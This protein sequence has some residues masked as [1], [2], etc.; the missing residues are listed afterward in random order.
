[1]DP[2]NYEA[3]CNRA[4]VKIKMKNFEK[5]LFDIETAI[6]VNEMYVD[7]WCLSLLAYVSLGNEKR[8]EQ[9]IGYITHLDMQRKAFDI[10]KEYVNKFEHFNVEWFKVLV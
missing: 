6:E 4:M 5:A 10:I 3:L 2:T 7:A 9:N 8:A 1:T